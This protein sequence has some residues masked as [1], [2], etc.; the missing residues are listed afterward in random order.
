MFKK[1]IRLVFICI[2][3]LLLLTTAN[4]Q[5]IIK[6]E[7]QQVLNVSKKID[8]VNIIVNFTNRIDFHT[9]KHKG[10]HNRSKLIRAAKVQSEKSQLELIRFLEKNNIYHYKKL[11][12]INS[13]AITVNVDMVSK[14]AAF[15]DVSEI[16]EDQ[17]ITL[18]TTTSNAPGIPELN[19]E[20]VKA[21]AVWSLGFTG[22]GT[23]IG[24]IGSGVDGYH[25]DLAPRFRGGGN[26]WFDAT[27]DPKTTIPFDADKVTYHGTGVMGI[28]LGGS[29]SGV[30]IGVAPGAK[31]IAAKIFSLDPNTNTLVSKGQYIVEAFQWM[32]DP[33]GDPNTQD[34][35][36]VVN[37]SWNL[38]AVNTCDTTYQASIDALK[39]A[40]ISVVF[41]AGNSGPG[42]STSLS[43]ANNQNTISVGAV[44]DSLA[45]E[46]YSSRGSTPT[47][48]IGCS[49][50]G[51]TDVYPNIVAPGLTIYTAD[52]S[53]AGTNPNPYTF[54]TGTSFAAPHISGALA[55]LK[56]AFPNS[57]SAERE[58]ALRLAANGI[59][60]GETGNDNSYGW[61][62]LDLD[63]AYQVLLNGGGLVTIA[64]YVK[65]HLNSVVP[66]SIATP[67][68]VLTD[69]LADARV[70]SSNKIDPSSVSIISNPVNGIASIDD[71]TGVVSYTPAKGFIGNDSF[72]YNVSDTLG[73]ISN[74]GLV[75]LLVKEKVV[76]APVVPS[77][78]SSSGGG[79]CTLQLNSQF[80]PMF[81][82]FLLFAIFYISRRNNYLERFLL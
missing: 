67:I 31:W 56:S 20:Q 57:T 53:S 42:L 16:H 4:A 70:D 36:D 51:P 68:L 2:A 49:V 9:T 34:A 21:P 74:T 12:L 19:I 10:K 45:I 79:G 72:T 82:I 60:L 37:N 62:F 18:N 8:Q 77:S 35:P 66:D 29:H 13:L 38:T 1:I 32:L 81:P 69:A 27:K 75:D 73:N 39:A 58:D 33:D 26:S 54:Q 3:G 55:V 78:S 65:N 46:I 59:D 15:A 5:G 64:P 28:A 63:G 80:D 17:I 7:L 40:D 48:P 14:I 43:P 76:I 71:Q 50:A 44:D 22:Q 47:S 41:S 11:W 23:V 25:P 6:T 52:G 24:I 61:G 30:N